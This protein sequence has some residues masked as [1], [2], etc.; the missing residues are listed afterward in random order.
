MDSGRYRSQYQTVNVK[1]TVED[2]NDNKPVFAKYPY[3]VQIAPYVNIGSEILR[4]TA[5]DRDRGANGEIVYKMSDDYQASKFRINANTGTISSVV[6]LASDVGRTFHV[7]V[8]ASD[9]GTPPLM[10][11]CLVE[12]KVVDGY[13]NAAIVLKFQNTS[14]MA[15]ILENAPVGET[16]IQVRNGER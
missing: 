12:I 15:R 3:T 14:Y 5:T 7:E 10:A 8:I 6:S 16:V 9:R 13:E 2:V 4:V 1:I 11:S